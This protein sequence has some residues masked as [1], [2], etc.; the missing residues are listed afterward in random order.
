MGTTRNALACSL[1][2]DFAFQAFRRLRQQSGNLIASPYSLYLTLAMLRLGAKGETLGQMQ[3]VLGQMGSEVDFHE[4]FKAL[5]QSLYDAAGRSS[6]EVANGL[7]SNPSFDFQEQALKEFEDYYEGRLGSLSESP[8]DTAK[9]VNSWIE[10]ATRGQIKDLVSPEMIDGL[11]SL[12]L[13]NAIHF[14]GHWSNP[15]KLE[16]TRS[17]S[18]WDGDQRLSAP[19]MIDFE[20]T[21]KSSRGPVLYASEDGWDML[22]L[23]YKTSRFSLLIIKPTVLNRLEGIETRSQL[24]EKVMGE[25]W[26][27]PPQLACSLEDIE[28][29]FTCS[30]LE[31]RVKRLKNGNDVVVN[32]PRFDLRSRFSCVD[33]LRDLGLGELFDQRSDL[34]GLIA[35]QPS[36]VDLVL[37][38]ARMTVDETGTVA[39]AASGLMGTRGCPAMKLFRADHPFLVL[40]RDRRSGAVLFFGRVQ[41]PVG[42]CAGVT[43]SPRERFEAHSKQP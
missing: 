36:W 25:G 29:A 6:F 37:H 41:D 21:V 39:A 3:A 27:R 20:E 22:D 24:I 28:E 12:V 26:I 35:D 38:E 17:Q 32:M 40:L 30:E 14:R 4:Q 10:R 9:A 18:F 34:S 16:Q 42:E 13:V 15:F 43:N 11:T 8:K 19:M 23:P 5:R 33:M 31:R 7:W 1:L 2:N